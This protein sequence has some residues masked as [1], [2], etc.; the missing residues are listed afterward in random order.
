METLEELVDE[1]R[2][3]EDDDRD[4]RDCLRTVT[5]PKIRCGTFPEPSTGRQRR[6]G[7]LEG[8]GTKPLEIFYFSRAA[9]KVRDGLE[10]GTPPRWV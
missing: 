8:A 4:V 5:E 10:R 3:D 6:E 7:L 1:D 2:R 9:P